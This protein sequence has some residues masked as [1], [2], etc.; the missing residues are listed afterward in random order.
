MAERDREQY[1]PSVLHSVEVLLYADDVLEKRSGTLNAGE[2]IYFGISI[3]GKTSVK[4]VVTN[5]DGDATGD[6]AVIGNPTLV[7][8]RRVDMPKG[9]LPAAAEIKM[10]DIDWVSA[11][12]LHSDKGA[13]FVDKNETGGPLS[14]GNSL[15]ITNNGLWFHPNYGE[16]Q[17]A[18][19]V[20]D[21]TTLQPSRFVAAFG[22]SD[23][24]VGAQDGYVGAA[25]ASL[26]S[27]QFIF[28]LDGEVV[29]SHDFIN[30][31]KVGA[32]DLDLTGKSTLTVRMTSYDGVHT[33]DA[34][35]ISGGFIQ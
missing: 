32:I 14:I 34:G 1:V 4:L 22:L 19:V 10:S 6:V 28:L 12:S 21:L 15:L 25:N 31:V 5:A 11:A 18:E 27:I 29:E 26:R 33:C 3:K 7:V 8:S 17:H 2:Y 23:E 13:P 24:Y 20:F 35:V 9:A 30:S 16:G